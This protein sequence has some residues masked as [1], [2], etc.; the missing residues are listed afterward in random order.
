MQK[1]YLIIE[2]AP[3]VLSVRE[4]VCLPRQVGATRINKVHTGQLAPLCNLLKPQV[5]L[6][7]PSIIMRTKECLR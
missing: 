5:L 6:Q 4:D 1:N 2:D 3:K 7:A